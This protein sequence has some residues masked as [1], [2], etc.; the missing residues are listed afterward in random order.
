ML[1]PAI[2]FAE[3]GYFVHERLSYNSWQNNLNRSQNTEAKSL[4]SIQGEAPLPGQK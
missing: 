4:F 1:K 2:N 3:N